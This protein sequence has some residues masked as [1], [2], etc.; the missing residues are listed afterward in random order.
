MKAQ[1]GIYL[2]PRASRGYTKQQQQQKRTRNLE[3]ANHLST[4]I[5]QYAELG[6]KILGILSVP[7]LSVLQSLMLRFMHWPPEHYPGIHRK[8]CFFRHLALTSSDWQIVFFQDIL[9]HTEQLHY[10]WQGLDVEGSE[11]WEIQIFL[12]Q[13]CAR[14]RKESSELFFVSLSGLTFSL[15]VWVCAKMCIC[16]YMWMVLLL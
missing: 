8:S 15:C 10:L 14:T 5:I 2:G 1:Y 7:N 4:N 6:C 16:I 11:R 13:A 12:F 9:G 3:V